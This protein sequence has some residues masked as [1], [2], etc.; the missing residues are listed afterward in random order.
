MVGFL[1]GSLYSLSLCVVSV[2]GMLGLGNGWCFFLFLGR[3]HDRVAFGAPE[4]WEIPLM[5][6]S[7]GFG[8]KFRGRFLILTG[9]ETASAVLSCDSGLG[10][11]H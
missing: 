5:E 7:V 3:Q 1:F 6:G 11:E 2:G 10:G 4:D 8:T 9:G